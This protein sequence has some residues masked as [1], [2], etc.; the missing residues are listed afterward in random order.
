MKF[1]RIIAALLVSLFVASSVV[2]QGGPT[3]NGTGGGNGGDDGVQNSGPVREIMKNITS[4][5][6]NQVGKIDHQ[7]TRDLVLPPLPG[8]QSFSESSEKED[9]FGTITSYGSN[10]TENTQVIMPPLKAFRQLNDSKVVLDMYKELI[11]KK[12]P[13]L[14]QTFMMVENGAG[15]GFS[16]ALN[17]VSNTSSN[18]VQANE[19]Q[20]KA[21]DITDPSGQM[22]DAWISSVFDNSEKHEGGWMAALLS[23]AHDSGSEKTDSQ[24]DNGRALESFDEIRPKTF[25]F[26]KLTEGSDQTGNDKGKKILLTTL[27]FQS[28]KKVKNNTRNIDGNNS[29][30]NDKINEVEK[31][32]KRYLGDM[33]IEFVQS[34]QGKA[35]RLFT[36]RRIAPEAEQG[37]QRRG[38]ARAQ[39]EETKVAWN[40]LHKVLEGYCNFRKKGVSGGAGDYTI[41]SFKLAMASDLIKMDDWTKT[42]APDI[43]LSFDLMLA[44]YDLFSRGEVNPQ[45]VKCED[46]GQKIDKMPTKLGKIQDDKPDDCSQPENGCLRDRVY[47]HM[48][49]I[50]GRSRAL[51][52]YALLFTI[53][54]KFATTP[55]QKML[56]QKVFDQTFEG[57]VI[58]DELA[59][60]R[61]RWSQVMNLLGSYKQNG[62]GIT[63]LSRPA[64]GALASNSN[65]DVKN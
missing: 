12:V 13:V 30:K 52:T 57:L 45:A 51:H 35:S 3:G 59:Q 42:S 14:F 50:L 65:V 49:Y 7:L 20:L 17:A 6:A 21:L 64:N 28:Q 2:A 8:E 11:T 48:S 43:P 37:G 26:T 19:F 61:D 46:L 25:D 55:G 36:I 5:T 33:E 63:G 56:L 38:L 54:E 39:L 15:A 1:D 18:I 24:G 4:R 58:Q 34:K 44:S 47:L 41:G 22:K 9:T 23:S 53:S 16:N 40:G 29:Y 10:T 32:F 27:L 31:E 60:N 62:T